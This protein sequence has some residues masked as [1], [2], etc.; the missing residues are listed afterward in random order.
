M[1]L[2]NL[3]KP[4]LLYFDDTGL[5][6]YPVSDAGLK[7]AAH[8]YNTNMSKHKG[9][10]EAVLFGKVLTDQQKQCMGMWKEALPIKY[11]INP[12]KHAPA[13]ET[14]II[15]DPFLKMAGINR[16]KQLSRC[17]WILSAKTATFY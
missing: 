8:H 16:L 9:K 11:R 7:I 6:L 13:S 5:P 1:E 12:G 10:L 15:K 14:G 4:D 17:W 2:I 3:Y